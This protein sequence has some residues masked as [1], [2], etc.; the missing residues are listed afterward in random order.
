MNTV[1]YFSMGNLQSTQCTTHLYFNFFKCSDISRKIPALVCWCTYVLSWLLN[2]LYGRLLPRG[3]IISREIASIY[4][5]SY[6]PNT[7]GLTL[8][9]DTS[10]QV[11]SIQPIGPNLSPNDSFQTSQNHLNQ[12]GKN[13]RIC[14]NRTKHVRYESTLTLAYHPPFL[15]LISSQV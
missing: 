6:S 14:L 8:D 13:T 2:N 11:F 9:W 4:L 1:F 15:S 5:L 12:R 7:V 10:F 3:A